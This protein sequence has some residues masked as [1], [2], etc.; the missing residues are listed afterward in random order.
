MKRTVILTVLIAVALLACG[1]TNTASIG[2]PTP[3][4]TGTPA[5][6][7]AAPEGQTGEPP[8]P[9]AAAPVLEISGSGDASQVVDLKTGTYVFTATHEGSGFFTV[10][11]ETENCHI[12]L[13][14]M[15]GPVSWVDAAGIRTP[16]RYYLNVTD[17]GDNPWSVRV[18][19]AAGTVDQSLPYHFAGTG[20]LVTGFFDLPAGEVPFAVQHDGRED[21]YVWL[22]DT[23]GNDIF[24]YPGWA[25]TFPAESQPQT[26]VEIPES[27]AY[28]LAVSCDGNW[29]VDIGE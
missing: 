5:T 4:P 3:T 19:R 23:E 12:G 15:D 18:D 25:V 8:V 7:P 17:E 22:Y 29:T 2:E 27:R 24:A 21:P 1:C 14:G 16:G 13:R 10:E 28:L 9:E 20:D 6:G 11:L 26:T